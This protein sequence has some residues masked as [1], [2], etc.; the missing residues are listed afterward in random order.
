MT[1]QLMTSPSG[2]RCLATARTDIKITKDTIYNCYSSCETFFQFD[3]SFWDLYYSPPAVYHHIWKNYNI[4]L[5]ERRSG[6]SPIPPV[7]SPLHDC[8][9]PTSA[10]NSV[11]TYNILSMIIWFFAMRSN[12]NLEKYCMFRLTIKLV[13]AQTN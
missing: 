10:T 7:A 11:A 1:L 5:E 9:D 3:V 4:G 8:E 2:W 13:L 12:R 6:P